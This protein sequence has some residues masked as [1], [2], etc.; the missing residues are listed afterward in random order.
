M[1]AARAPA[2]HTI[3]AATIHVV[4]PLMDIPSETTSVMISA[5]RVAMIPT[6]PVN[7]E[8]FRLHALEDQRRKNRLDQS[9]DDRHDD[10]GVEVHAHV[11][12]HQVGDDDA[13]QGGQEE[14]PGADEE[15]DH[16]A[17]R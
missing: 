2:S 4:R 11:R 8:A 5:T 9:E 7:A 13:D 14:D 1:N 12:Q 10:V 15:T 17:E 3:S 16:A 6:P